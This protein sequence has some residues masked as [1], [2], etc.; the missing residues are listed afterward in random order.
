MREWGDRSV[1]M[2]TPID[3]LLPSRGQYGKLSCVKVLIGIFTTYHNVIPKTII[4]LNYE[5]C[6]LTFIP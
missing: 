6:V 1:L 4:V 2:L 3:P 5:I